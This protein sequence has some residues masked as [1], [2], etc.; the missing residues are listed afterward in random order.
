MSQAVESKRNTAYRELSEGL[1]NRS[2]S[3]AL[4]GIGTA[5][6]FLILIGEAYR[7]PPSWGLLGTGLII[8]ALLTSPRKS[9]VATRRT[10]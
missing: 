3:V 2:R 1:L 6:L 9:T 4:L 5:G 7:Q 8:T 10:T